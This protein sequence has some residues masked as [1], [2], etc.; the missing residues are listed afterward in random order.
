M[1]S[2]QNLYVLVFVMAS[3]YLIDRTPNRPRAFWGACAFAILAT[4][5][6]GNGLFA[7]PV[8]A[9]MLW[10]LGQRRYAAIWSG[11]AVLT[12]V[13][14]F[15]GF[16]RSENLPSVY[17]SLIGNTGRAIDYFFTL[18]GSVFATSPEAPSRA[19]K[20]LLVLYLGLLVYLIRTRR[21]TDYLPMVGM[22]TFVYVTCLLLTATRS[23][24][25]VI[26]AT[27]P[28]YGILSVVLVAGI[29]VLL[30]EAVKHQ[31]ARL[32]VGL[33]FAAVA[34]YLF[35]TTQELNE[36]K[37]ADR[38][39]LLQLCAAFYNDN[40]QNLLVYWGTS[41]QEG[42]RIL[43]EAFRRKTYQ[44]PK[45]MLADLAST[46]RQ[47]D[48]AEVVPQGTITAEARPFETKD[49]IVFWNTWAVA[50]GMDAHAGRTE[51]IAQAPGQAY[52]FD[53]GK[54][55]RYDVANQMQSMQFAEAGFSSVLPK[56]SLKKG[57]YTLWLHLTD[58][59]SHA[60]KPLDQ[61]FVVN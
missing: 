8:G 52:A 48:A 36:V 19:G 39:R 57:Q 23:G 6:S 7:F 59:R 11:I 46:P 14:Y 34:V 45:V 15:W 17:D 35:F 49:H 27:S 42:Q 12:A 53:T 38:T 40:P 18:T 29:G 21:L 28:R 56:A 50:D 24:F 4:F 30:V 2:L 9:L 61:G 13:L 3:F 20:V 54:H 26:Q 10:L 44:I 47:L 5:T 33:G 43:N 1:A 55:M 60:Y 58:G 25:G 22:V 31:W 16:E 37:V 51:I 32:S 41:Q